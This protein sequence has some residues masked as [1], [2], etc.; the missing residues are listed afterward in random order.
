[1]GER[2]TLVLVPGLLCDGTVWSHQIDALRGRYLIQV[3]ELTDCT[4]IDAMARRVLD[5]APPEFSIA[6]HSMGAR[7]ALEVVALA[8]ER[9]RRLALLDTGTHSSQEG[10]AERRQQ[11][12]DLGARNGMLALAER[13]LPPMVRPGA[14]DSNPALRRALFAMVERMSPAI[15][16]NQI[17]ALLGRPDARPGLAAIR[18]P[19]LIGVGEHDAWSPPG[20]HEAI[21]AAIPHARYAVF[22]DSGHMAPMEAPDAVS[23]AMEEWMT[24]E[25]T[26]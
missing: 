26:A 25:P 13:W 10:E 11:L 5:Y 21:A 15:H 2:E 6:G 23:A 9:V 17:G 7:V 12:L 22:P 14:L 18:C 20:Q 16:R 19:V 3:P 24:T 4:S 1:M 8:P